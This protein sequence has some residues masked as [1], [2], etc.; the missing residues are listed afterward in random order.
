[1]NN[2]RPDIFTTFS[3]FIY[4]YNIISAIDLHPHVGQKLTAF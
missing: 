2:K 4:L 1:M 3:L